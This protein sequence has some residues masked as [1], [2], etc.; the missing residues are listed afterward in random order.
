MC[1][2]VVYL[3]RHRPQ[4]AMRIR[5]LFLSGWAHIIHSCHLIL[6]RFEY[7]LNPLKSLRSHSFTC[8]DWT[9]S[10]F[11]QTKTNKKYIRK[12]QCLLFSFQFVCYHY[13]GF[14]YWQQTIPIQIGTVE[15]NRRHLFDNE[16]G[17]YMWLNHF[18][19]A[20]NSSC[21]RLMVEICYVRQSS[22]CKYK[23][24]I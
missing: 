2:S 1:K 18:M 21:T 19:C 10:F 14:I 8:D 22:N 16:F 24:W 3:K 7:S 6:K 23:L 12:R 13:S 5:F 9:I 11:Y 20:I 17:F 15:K 4:L